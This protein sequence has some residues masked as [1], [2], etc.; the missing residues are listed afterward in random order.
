MD[1][2]IGEIRLFA[3]SRPPSN[4][5]LCQ[6]QLLPIVAYQPLFALIGF[7]YGGDGKTNFALPD[8]RGRVA[9]N[10]TSSMTFGSSGGS[11]A[12][13]LTSD[14]LPSHTHLLQAVSTA[15]TSGIP[16]GLYPAQIAKAS[17]S[18]TGPDAPCRYGEA[19]SPVSLDSSVV[20]AVGGG[21]A[22]ENRQP[23]LALNYSI[24]VCGLFPIRD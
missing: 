14:H 19:A 12:V 17:S 24:C 8:L 3:F 7:A 10:V 6:G 15:G 13:T 11:D 2:F 9:V 22:H 5:V 20:S 4:W 23:L 16:T 21:G 18:G 1:G